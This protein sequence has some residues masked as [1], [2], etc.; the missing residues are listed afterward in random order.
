M[1]EF[2]R[3]SCLEGRT[4][5]IEEIRPDFFPYVIKWR[6]DPELN[7]YINQPFKLTLENE[8]QWYENIY[9]KDITQGFY[10]MVDK[11]KRIPFGTV[12]Y[13]DMDFKE[14]TC[15]GGRLM[16][17]NHDYFGSVHFFEYGIVWA[18]WIYKLDGCHV[19]KGKIRYPEELHRNGLEQIELYRD[20]ADYMKVRQHRLDILNTVLS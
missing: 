12:G 16:L 14:R 3:P 6:N 7:K 17:G 15:I 18:D 13:T 4:V 5:V 9:K 1:K 8:R 2:K 11:E 20:K 19:N 10:V